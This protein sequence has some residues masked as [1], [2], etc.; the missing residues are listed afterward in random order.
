MGNAE[1][2]K[3]CLNRSKIKTQFLCQ[4]FHKLMA[5][6]KAGKDHDDIFDNLKAAVVETAMAK[7]EWE[8][9]AAEMLRVSF[10]P[11]LQ[12]FRTE[13]KLIC[14]KISFSLSQLLKLRCLQNFR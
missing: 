12:I 7:H 9:K 4:E 13:Q 2:G 14:Y 1:R 6:A 10:D 8:D 3:Y 11:V 5:K